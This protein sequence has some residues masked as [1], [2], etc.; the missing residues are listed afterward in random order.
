M[1]MSGEED[2][3]LCVKVT[4]QQQQGYIHRVKNIVWSLYGDSTRNR[5]VAASACQLQTA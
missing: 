3:A 5:E 2:E 1:V 4:F